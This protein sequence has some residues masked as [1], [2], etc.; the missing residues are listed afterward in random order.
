MTTIDWLRYEDLIAVLTA[1]GFTATPLPGGGQLFR[2]PHGALLGFPAIAPD[3]AVINYHYGA[4]R[5]A[6]VDYGIMTRDAFELELLQ[7]AHRLPT[8]A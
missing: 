4:A 1:H 5:A 6:M 8:P 2:H 3:H 7:A